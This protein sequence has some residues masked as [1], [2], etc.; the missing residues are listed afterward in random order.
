[1][2]RRLW[3]VCPICGKK[4]IR[5]RPGGSAQGI[6]LRCKHCKN[7]IEIKIEKK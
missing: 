4:L 3:Y 1:M 5:F 2:E 6:F 7:E